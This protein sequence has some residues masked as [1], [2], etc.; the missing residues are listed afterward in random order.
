MA[1]FE[2]IK[3]LHPILQEIE[4]QTDPHRFMEPYDAEKVKKANELHKKVYEV[5]IHRGIAVMDLLIRTMDILDC[6]YDP[7][8]IYDYLLK[9]YDPTKHNSEFDFFNN[10]CQKI[11]QV[12]DNIREMNQLIKEENEKRK[13]TRKAIRVEKLKRED[14]VGIGAY[15][16]KWLRG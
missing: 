5:D 12:K 1:E 7:Q 9:L 4:K 15:I 11:S 8:L 16:I 6:T 3:P 14:D 2:P 13:A 10:L